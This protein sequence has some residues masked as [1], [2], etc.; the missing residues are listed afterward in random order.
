M[1]TLSRARLAFGHGTTLGSLLAD[2]AEVHGPRRLVTDEEG[3]QLTYRQAAKR[4]NRWAG[5][6]AAK[7]APGDRVVLHTANHYHHTGRRE[8]R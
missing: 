5:G 8:Q 2:L 6:I 7:A 3:R 1:R 4:V